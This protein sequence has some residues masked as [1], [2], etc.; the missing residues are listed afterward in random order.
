MYGG[1]ITI[2]Q[3]N[4]QTNKQTNTKPNQLPFNKWSLP[5]TIGL[6]LYLTLLELSQNLAK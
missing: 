2:K 4:K 6:G 3:L 5:T 1:N